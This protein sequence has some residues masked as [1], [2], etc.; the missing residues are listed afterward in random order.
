MII[1]P[2]SRL[3]E[4]INDLQSVIVLVTRNPL[5]AMDTTAHTL[6]T[7]KNRSSRNIIP[8]GN[9]E[10]LQRSLF[11]MINEHTLKLIP[12]E[13][14]AIS[15]DEEKAEEEEK[16]KE[17]EK[18]GEAGASSPAIQMVYTNPM[19]ANNRSR[20][21]IRDL[22]AI[23]ESDSSDSDEEAEEHA[24]DKVE[25]SAPPT[26]PPTLT[27][28]PMAISTIPEEGD[29]DSPQPARHP[30]EAEALR[31]VSSPA[32]RSPMLLRNPYQDGTI[33]SELCRQLMRNGTL[34]AAT[35]MV[36]SFRVVMRDL[37]KEQEY[38][39]VAHV[40][41]MVEDSSSV[42]MKMRRMIKNLHNDPYYDRRRLPWLSVS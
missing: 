41:D 1:N 7:A 2:Y 12:L 30:E 35:D 38:Q 26:A 20:R 29:E 14:E 42:R 8:L 9:T 21:S 6:Y 40:F 36:E 22:D 28:L 24:I 5:Q 32:E 33:Q 4:H 23:G 18:E 19:R 17:K 13:L 37:E 39:P 15:D 11:N 16:E 34:T 27:K 31:N 25:M 10:T 3:Y